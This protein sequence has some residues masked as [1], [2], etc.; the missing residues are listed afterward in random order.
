M[1][2][3]W[4]Q[5]VDDALSSVEP[6]PERRE[7]LKGR[8]RDEGSLGMLYSAW[9]SGGDPTRIARLIIGLARKEM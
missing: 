6:N 1:D 8:L 9:K 3:R 4:Q 5:M 2:D 7:L